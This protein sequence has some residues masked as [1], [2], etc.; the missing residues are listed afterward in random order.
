MFRLYLKDES[1][2]DPEDGLY[3]LLAQDG[4]Y[5]VKQNVCFKSSVRVD[6]LADLEEH[7][8]AVELRLPPLPFELV[9]EAVL[10]FREVL[11]RHGSEAVLLIYFVPEGRRYQMVCPI[12]Y[13]SQTDCDYAIEASPPGYRLV[14]TVH[15]HCSG[16]AFHSPTDD[17]DE[18]ETEGLHIIISDLDKELSYSCS[19]IADGRRLPLPVSRVFSDF[20]TQRVAKGRPSTQVRRWLEQVTK[21]EMEPVNDVVAEQ[22][23]TMLD[24][25]PLSIV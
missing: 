21:K 9:E 7:Q 6:G 15:S 8:E 10:F 16:P 3:Y 22:A 11:H 4:L 25:D 18:A 5:Q 1:F 17:T 2:V 19:L 20:R 13:V 12:Q 14:G 24:M 23:L